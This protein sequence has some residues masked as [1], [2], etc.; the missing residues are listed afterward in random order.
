[1]SCPLVAMVFVATLAACASP[2]GE[3]TIDGGLPSC[4]IHDCPGDP[5]ATVC[6][7]CFHHFADEECSPGFVCSCELQCVKGPRSYDAGVCSSDH[8]DAGVDSGVVDAGGA[9]PDA[10]HH[11]WPACDDRHLPGT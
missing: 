4:W 10:Q 6:G 3:S 1:M 5:G 11:D 7:V 2:A 8:L 9:T